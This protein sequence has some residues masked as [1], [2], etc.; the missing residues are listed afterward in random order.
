MV[1][2]LYPNKAAPKKKKKKRI[3]CDFNYKMTRTGNTNLC[4]QKSG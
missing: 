2:E 3:Q 1:Y 4:Y